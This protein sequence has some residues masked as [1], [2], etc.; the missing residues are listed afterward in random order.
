MRLRAGDRYRYVGLEG[1]PDFQVGKVTFTLLAADPEGNILVRKT[2]AGTGEV[3]ISIP[4]SNVAKMIE[5]GIWEPLTAQD[6]EL[7]TVEEVAAWLGTTPS[8]LYVRRH[9]AQGPPSFRQGHQ[10]LYRRPEVQAWIEACAAA[11]TSKN[12]DEA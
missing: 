4:V 8:A 9:R 11:E 3:D 2:W 1:G 10:V 6:D 12:E 5:L 7:L